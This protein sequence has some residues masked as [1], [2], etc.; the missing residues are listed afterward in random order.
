[1]YLMCPTLRSQ[2]VFIPPLCTK[3]EDD[4]RP[5]PRIA[6]AGVL[7][8]SEDTT[9]TY[10]EDGGARIC[11]FGCAAGNLV[12]GCNSKVKKSVWYIR[13]ISDLHYLVNYLYGQFSF[14]GVCLWCG[15]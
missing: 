5:L 1:M 12:H 11:A 3:N 4:V 2:H 8:S 6:G 13:W 14:E 15:Y 9:H 7:P 10:N